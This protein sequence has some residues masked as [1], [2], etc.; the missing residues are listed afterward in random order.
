MFC[1][2]WVT[3]HVAIT[4]NTVQCLRRTSDTSVLEIKATIQ[5]LHTHTHTHIHTHTHTH[6]P[7]PRP[8]EKLVCH[9]LSPITR[10]KSKQVARNIGI[11]NKSTFYIARQSHADFCCLN[12]LL[13]V[14]SVCDLSFQFYLPN[15][16]SDFRVRKFVHHH[17][18]N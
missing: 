6:K 12:I 13:P 4:L 1:W 18:F 9:S 15:T 2:W 17:T 16:A 7:S 11:V 8:K 3:L 5:L 14:G 10:T